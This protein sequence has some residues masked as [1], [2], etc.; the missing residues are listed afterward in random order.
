MRL[1]YPVCDSVAL[2]GTTFTGLVRT[3]YVL[4]PSVLLVYLPLALRGLAVYIVS[5]YSPSGVQQFR[6][7]VSSPFNIEHVSLNVLCSHISP[8]IYIS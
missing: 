7:L 8:L 5:G 1:S 6:Y 3:Q 2:T 4:V